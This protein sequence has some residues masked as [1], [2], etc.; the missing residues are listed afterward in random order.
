MTDLRLADL[1][2]LPE[3]ERHEALRAISRREPGSRLLRSDLRGATT[4]KGPAAE[5]ADQLPT[6][7]QDRILARVQVEQEAL[8]S[9]EISARE[10]FEKLL[11]LPV[12]RAETLVRNS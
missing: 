9:E 2:R 12:S 4:L 8:D 7:W 6:G 3:R 11:E 1:F 5:A 10:Q